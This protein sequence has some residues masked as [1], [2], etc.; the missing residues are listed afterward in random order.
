MTT[1]NG[2]DAVLPSSNFRTPDSPRIKVY[3]V[4]D[5][6]VVR[7]GLSLLLSMEP[8]LVCCGQAETILEAMRGIETT[9]PD[10]A[11]VDLSLRGASGLELV[12]KL[13]ACHPELPVV[14]LSMHDETLY[15]ERVLKAGAMAYVMKDEAQ[16]TILTAIRKVKA[17]GLYLSE[18]MSG[19]L[20]SMFLQGPNA[21]GNSRI[22]QLSDR[23]IEV[24]ELIGRGITTREIA[25]QLNL[26]IKTVEA[27]REHIKKKMKLADATQLLQHA[28]HW[29]QNEGQP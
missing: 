3:I 26:S 23:E 19:R 21:P 1:T 24:F 11:V 20:L 4:D 28:I 8:D 29:V 25:G 15:A 22:G 9:R 7:Q 14:V 10:V 2:S 13:H 18:R 5:H 27:H 12:K 6:P 16:C 17:G